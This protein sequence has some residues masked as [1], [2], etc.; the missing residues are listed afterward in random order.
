M[1]SIY[2]LVCKKTHCVRNYHRLL[3]LCTEESTAF[4][5]KKSFSIQV[6]QGVSPFSL[7]LPD[8]ISNKESKKEPLA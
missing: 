8:I 2:A 1:F 7:A 4:L 3:D 6:S 5:I